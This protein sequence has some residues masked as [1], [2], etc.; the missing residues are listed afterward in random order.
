VDCWSGRARDHDGHLGDGGSEP[1]EPRIDSADELRDL[2]EMIAL[3]TMAHP[4][5]QLLERL[6]AEPAQTAR[7]ERTEPG[8]V[9]EPVILG[10]VLAATDTARVSNGERRNA[11]IRPRSTATQVTRRTFAAVWA[12]LKSRIPRPDTSAVEVLEPHSARSRCRRWGCLTST[13]ERVG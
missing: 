5:Q 11:T 3:G 13:M 4:V 6:C 9:D 8:A 2:L 1:V 12:C 10:R 7:V